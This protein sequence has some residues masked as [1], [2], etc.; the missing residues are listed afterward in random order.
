M[1]YATQMAGSFAPEGVKL[2]VL[3]EKLDPFNCTGDLGFFMR[4]QGPG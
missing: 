3:K 2:L 4:G 1:A